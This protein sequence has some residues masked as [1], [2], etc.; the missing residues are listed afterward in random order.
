MEM[1]FTFQPI[2]AREKLYP[3]LI[4]YEYSLETFRTLW[5]EEKL[6]PTLIKYEYSPET[7]RTLWKKKSLQPDPG[8]ERRSFGRP[9]TIQTE[10]TA[11]QYTKL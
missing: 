5:I 3:T 2:Y 8:I 9:V 4:K 7:F 6:Y 1:S 11:L 10:L